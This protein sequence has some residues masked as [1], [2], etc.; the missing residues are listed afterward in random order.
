MLDFVPSVTFPFWLVWVGLA[1]LL[2]L[3]DLALTGA[4]LFLVGAAIGAFAAAFAAS[5]GGSMEVQAWTMLIGTALA[6]PPIL[7][8]RPRGNARNKHREAG[9]AEGKTAEVVEW[10]DRYGIYLEG[11]FY[12][13]RYV[14]QSIPQTGQR[15][16]VQRMEST[17]AIVTDVPDR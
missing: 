14:D 2:L 1:A 13:V 8:L 7:M 6:T 10:G 16:R 11:D 4:Q 12:R 17:T 9:W 15:V 5:L 3:V